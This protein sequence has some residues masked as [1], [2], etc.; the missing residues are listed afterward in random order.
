[1]IITNLSK[2]LEREASHSLLLYIE[3]AVNRTLE[4]WP[5]FDAFVNVN[6]RLMESNFTYTDIEEECGEKNVPWKLYEL[7]QRIPVFLV[8]KEDVLNVDCLEQEA[9][10]QKDFYTDTLGLY[11]S[12]YPERSYPL[13]RCKNKAAVKRMGMSGK[14][15][16]WIVIFV[17]TIHEM[18]LQEG[19]DFKR[20][21][22]SVLVHEYMH[23]LMDT[24]KKPGVYIPSL[25]AY[26]TPF[27]NY[28]E[29][30]FANALTAIFG[31]M[32]G[33]FSSEIMESQPLP[34]KMGY[35]Y[36]ELFGYDVLRMAKEYVK[37]KYE[38]LDE[39]F[40]NEWFKIVNKNQID[41]NRLKMLE[42]YRTTP[43]IK[44]MEEYFSFSYSGIRGFISSWIREWENKNRQLPSTEDLMSELGLK[45]H[46]FDE[47]LLSEI[48]D[49]AVLDEIIKRKDKKG[50]I[51][52]RESMFEHTKPIKLRDY[53]I[54]LK[55]N[56]ELDEV[57]ELAR[58]AGAEIY[59]LNCLSSNNSHRNV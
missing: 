2:S 7:F 9:F 33:G 40:K 1:M 12:S 19:Y 41:F 47:H 18:C 59:G 36:S 29:E 42:E 37:Q 39:D 51:K 49:H 53:N 38:G 56:W 43:F 30:L 16:R 44:F 4:G 50:S 55:F 54:A 48:K 32:E 17:D 21:T 22:L 11:L 45:E 3:L 31:R 20:I 15:S 24:G 34:Y 46:Q 13:A 58:K 52:H 8:D 57:K 25:V 10:K 6:S 35:E 23:A 5:E 28:N 26:N 27:G 14:N